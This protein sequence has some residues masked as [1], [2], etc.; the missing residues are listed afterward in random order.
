MIEVRGHLHRE[1]PARDERRGE[2]REKRLVPGEP[3]QDRIREDEVVAPFGVEIRDVALFEAE[4]AAG[5]GAGPAEHRLRAV[6]TE[7]LRGLEPL[8]KKPRQLARAA[9]EIDDAHAGTSIDEREQVEERPA[10]LV[11]EALVLV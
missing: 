3:V 7:R 1:L 8:V 4:P 11:V 6:E 2:P 10:P 9:A 5:E